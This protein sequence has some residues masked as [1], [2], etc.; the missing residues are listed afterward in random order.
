MRIND[1]NTVLE[2]TKCSVQNNREYQIQKVIYNV[3]RFFGGDKTIKEI[4]SQKLVCENRSTY[5]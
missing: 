1:N 4:L 3:N 5:N 2:K